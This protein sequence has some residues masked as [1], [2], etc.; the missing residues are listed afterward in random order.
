MKKQT[1]LLL[2]IA[3][4]LIKAGNSYSQCIPDTITCRD[5]LIPGQIC[6]EILPDGYL[7]ITYNQSVTILPPS[8]A[9]FND[10]PFAIA[11]IKIDTIINLPPGIVYELSALELYPDTAYCVLLSG[12]PSE[13][14]EFNISI[15]VVPYVLFLDSIIEGPL[16]VND[17]S[18]KITVYEPSKIKKMHADEFGVIIDGPNPFSESIKLG[19]MMDEFSPVQL[20][21]CNYLGLLV[22]SEWLNAKPGMNHFRFTGG[23]LAP[24]Y[25]IY[26]IINKQVIHSGKLI[27]SR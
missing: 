16:V 17:T 23:D 18:V 6:P 24:G 5:T 13:T 1:L 27:K 4:I 8:W 21:I 12:I 11:K 19:F 2:Y 26:S 20:H 22:Y 3:L 15:Q 7:G 9:I 14:G 10:N 25:Y